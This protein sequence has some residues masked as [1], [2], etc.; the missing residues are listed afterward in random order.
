MW[1]GEFSETAGL[2]VATVPFY[3]RTGLLRPKQGSVGGARPYMEFSQKDVRTVSAIRT[4]QAMGMSLAEIKLLV[5]E[6]RAGGKD[7][8]LQAMIAQ[9]DRLNERAV[10]LSAILQFVDA[11]IRWL[12]RGAV[13]TPPEL[14]I[15]GRIH[16]ARV[17]NRT[18]ARP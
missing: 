2:N 13:G 4:G 16:A 15:D 3:V 9:R 12:H 5:S 17:K 7:R 18:S 8:M 1:I 6:R 14:S 11:K 10:E